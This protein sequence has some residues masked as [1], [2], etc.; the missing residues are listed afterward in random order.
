MCSLCPWLFKMAKRFFRATFY[1][2]RTKKTALVLLLLFMVHLIFV[3][4]LFF[5]DSVDNRAVR[6]NEIIQKIGNVIYL[7]QA[8]PKKNRLAAIKAID[9]PA[10]QVTLTNHPASLY[11]YNK[12]EYW[13]I[14]HTL[15]NNIPSYFISV[16]LNNNQWLNI[17]A[18]PYTRHILNHL[19]LLGLEFIIFLA[20]FGTLWS[21]D[22]FTAPL[23]KI[24]SSVEQ[25]GID[26]E[27]KP[28]DVYGPK[29]VREASEALNQMQNR[30][31]QLVHNRTQLLAA[32]SHDLRTPIA[33]AQLRLQFIEDSDY[34]TQ[35]LND[36]S[37]MDH[38]ISEAL[39]FARQDTQYEEMK[40]VDLVSLILS[41]CDDA[42]DMGHQ[43]AFYTNAH[44]IGFVGRPI[45]LK[46]A[47][48]N[49]INNAIR[50]AGG[51]TVSIEKHGKK[52]TIIVEDEGSGIPESEFE[53]VFEPF[54]RGEQSRS[55][56][57]GGVGLGLAVTRDVILAHHGRIK[58]EN[59][60]TGG[61][62]IS[63]Y[64]VNAV[65]I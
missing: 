63:I 50:Y 19:F 1:F 54:Y 57:T 4:H 22:R 55:R 31:M 28:F 62:K 47:F 10:I 12:F 9:D 41:I 39:S 42:G 44:R 11:Q 30:I 36:L 56:D 53:K 34:K 26:L 49:L 32:I 48:T 45:A 64:F 7:V 6:K 15:E 35:L 25:L 21:I 60:K 2:L 29:V 3:V 8:A 24:K 16:Q 37:E 46:R 27:T 65:G 17:K 14:I 61:L 13:K 59:K 51:V 58:L 23:K 20:V 5:D 18:T 43:A 40:P 38:M 33:R 52:I